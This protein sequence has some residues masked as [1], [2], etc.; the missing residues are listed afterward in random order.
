L[1]HLIYASSS[2]VYGG[3]TKIPFSE[4]HSVD[5]PVSLYAASKKADELIGHVYSHLYNIPSTGLR[6]FT[7]YG[8]W[9]RPD[10]AAFIFTEAIFKGVPIK[11]FNDG[12]MHRDF[13]FIDDVVRGIMLVMNAPP[14]SEDIS[15]PNR[16]YNI[17]NNRSEPLLR[18][19]EVLERATGLKAKKEFVPMQPGDVKQTYADIDLIRNDHGYEPSIP[20]DEGIPLFVEWYRQYYNL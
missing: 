7:V 14:K 2:S 4:S 19:V 18:F 12:H 16:I 3:N 5:N 11:I 20:I 10:M 9:G 8:P 6:F 1:Q 13:T 17:G 15:V